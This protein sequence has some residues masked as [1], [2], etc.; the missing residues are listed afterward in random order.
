MRLRTL[1][2]CLC[3][4]GCA[5]PAAARTPAERDV[6]ALVSGFCDSWNRHDATALAALMAQDGDFV[7]VASR[8]FHGRHDIELYHRRLFAGRYR[9]STFL[10]RAVRFRFVTPRLAVV[11]WIWQLSGNTDAAGAAR[12][13]SWGMMSMV[14]ARR[15]KRWSIVTAHESTGRK[16]PA[17]E[18]LGID[19]PMPLPDDLP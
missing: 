11:H 10:S 13:P 3:L 9:Q 1:L 18:E 17:G 6:E 19:L 14:A 7:T 15:G 16:A 2:L 4:L 5:V 8:W 12:P